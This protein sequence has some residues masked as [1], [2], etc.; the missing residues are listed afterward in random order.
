[1]TPRWLDRRHTV[2]NPKRRQAAALHSAIKQDGW[3]TS[4][5]QCRIRATGIDDYKLRWRV[6]LADGF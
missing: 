3:F 2:R 1:M 4:V 5:L 6:R